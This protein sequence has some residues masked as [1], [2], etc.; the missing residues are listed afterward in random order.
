[1]LN[2]AIVGLGWWGQHIVKSLNNKSKKIKLVQAVDLYPESVGEFA[3][4]HNLPLTDDLPETLQRSDIDVVILVTPHS[5]H[6][7]QIVTAAQC[8]KHVF[9]EKPLA[10]TKDSAGKAIRTCEQH[11]ITLGVGHERRWEP[12]MLELKRMS[13]QKELGTL[14]HVESSFNHDIFLKVAPED[15]RARKS[16][17]PNMGMTGM[18]VHLTDAYIDMFGK[19]ESV[20]AQTTKRVA[21]FDGGDVISIQIRFESG[22]LGYINSII[23]TPFFTRFHVFG[24]EGWAEIRDSNHPQQV[25]ISY[26]TVCMTGGKPNTTEYQWIDT[27]RANIEAFADAVNGNSEYPINNDQKLHNIAVLDAIFKSVDTEHTVF[28]SD[29]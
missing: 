22:M 7:Q 16:E 13:E 5:C 26:L 18:G 12:A 9:V 15:W 10:L 20:F 24:S 8:G 29:N 14:L 11:G 17:S 2:A 27:V 1:M 28:L 3:A 6:E 21:P 4:Q 25:G 23:A 19:F